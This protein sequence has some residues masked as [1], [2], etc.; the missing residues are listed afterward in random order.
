MANEQRELFP[1]TPP[2]P[3]EPPAAVPATPAPGAQGAPPAPP[4]APPAPPASPAAAVP[5]TPATPAVPGVAPATP[6]T[7]ATPPSPPPRAWKQPEGYT[8]PDHIASALDKAITDGMKPEHADVLLNSHIDLLKKQEQG[9][10]AAVQQTMQDWAQKTT[11]DRDFGGP[12]F[13]A[14]REAAKAF[15]DKF[16]DDDLRRFL[17]ESG[18]GYHPGV[19]KAF[20]R[21]QQFI[22]TRMTEETLANVAPRSGGGR[23]TPLTQTER[24]ARLYDSPDMQRLQ[25]K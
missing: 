3:V 25:K 12:K 8:V 2:K 23:T 5:A 22:S 13:E 14:S 6:A 9:R 15:V 1:P 20:A 17:T 16:G 11:T 21:A 18:A 4:A 19:F 7:P 24:L 10:A